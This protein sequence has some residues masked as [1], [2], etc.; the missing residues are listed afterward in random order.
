MTQGVLSRRS[1]EQFTVTYR[2]PAVEG[3]RMDV[4]ALAP[5][6]IALSRSIQEAQHVLDPLAP[7][8]ALDVRAVRDGSFAVDL[9]LT[10][11]SL[12][13]GALDLLT[14]RDATAIVNLAE[15]VGAVFGGYKLTR[16]LNRRIR[17]REPLPNG[18]VR[19]AFDDGQ[20]LTIPETSLA[21]VG[22]KGFRESARD[23]VAPL[24]DEG[25]TNVELSRVGDEPVLI[26]RADLAGF[27][28]P[29]TPEQE[30][31]DYEQ[32]SALRPVTVAFTE[33]NKWRVYDGETT[34]FATIL[35]QV[36]LD[37]VEAGDESF[38][39]SDILRARVRTR[40]WRDAEG[41]LRTERQ[42]LQVLQHLPGSRDVPLPFDEESAD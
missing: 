39:K 29:P 37:R 20:Q 7:R 22:D 18:M 16:W 30:L 32:V 34:F 41:E 5:A 2:G 25:M 42:I 24:R 21:I 10:E 8:P 13:Q 6:L 35:D 40:Q 12:I 9:V 28:L 23:A 1:E 31:A 3:G 17:G 11:G 19:I 36:F 4:Q 33:G 27:D 14:G 26:E 15:L 38:S